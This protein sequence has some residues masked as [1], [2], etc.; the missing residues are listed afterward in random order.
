[1]R[2][3]MPVSVLSAIAGLGAMMAASPAAAAVLTVPAQFPDIQAAVDAASPRDQIVVRSGTYCGATVDK[4]LTLIGRG[5]PVIVGCADGPALGNG[6]RVGFLLPGADG[7]SAASGTSIVGFTFEGRGVSNTNLEP[8]AFGVLGRFANDVRV[9]SN[10]FLGTV[11]A[12][13]NTAGDRWAIVSNSIEDLTVFDCTVLCTGGDGIVLQSARA[14]LAVP[15]GADL[16]VNR[17]EFN[18]VANNRITGAIPDG[19]DVF[20]LA[21]VLVL[22]G[23]NNAIVRN[24][25][26]IPDNPLSEAVG[27]GIV[28]ANECCGIAG[29][30]DPGSRNTFLGFNDVRGSEIG[31]VIDGVGG[32]NTAGLSLLNNR[33]SIE[34]EGVFSP[35]TPRSRPR[36]FRGRGFNQRA[37]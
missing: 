28:V 37:S 12:V 2:R 22:A 24:T 30:I 1:M 11:Q 15:G 32:A 36:L 21:G 18:L 7:A 8:I 31:I 5:D 14:P 9:V 19:F 35:S 34:L 29:G 10:R 13:T 4:P 6:A 26:A 27:Q 23:D 16:A 20:S 3:F 33:G 17:P 25:V